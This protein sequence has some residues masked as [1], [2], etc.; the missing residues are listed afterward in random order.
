MEELATALDDVQQLFS[1]AKQRKAYIL[2]G[3]HVLDYFLISE[4]FT[5]QE[6]IK[7][8]RVDFE[9][10]MKAKGKN[11]RLDGIRGWKGC[12]GFCLNLPTVG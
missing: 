4:H 12:W 6:E 9:N 11:E 5:A 2:F 1:D 3:L 8:L 10:E 7:Q